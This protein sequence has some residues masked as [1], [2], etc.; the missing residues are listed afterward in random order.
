MKP[1]EAAALIGIHPNTIRA[2]SAGDFKAYLSHGAQGGEGR[3][4]DLTELDVKILAYVNMLKESGKP[5]DEIHITLGQLQNDDWLDLPPLPNG[6]NM[7]PMPVV[8]AASLDTAIQAERRALLRE[9]ASLQ[10]RL[11]H[12]EEQL[13]DEQ[14][15]RR[16]DNERFLR[17]MGD[18]RA[19]LAEAKAVLK[20][21]EQGRLKPPTDK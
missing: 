12:V 19:E 13:S 14:K 21:Y 8:P 1:H 10:E 15:A 16:E 5:L 11:A 18:T 9:I 6:S 20:L 7:M 3:S 4:R 2:W 17:E